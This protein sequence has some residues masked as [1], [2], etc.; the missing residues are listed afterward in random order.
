MRIKFQPYTT[1]Q[2]EK[3]VQ[4]RLECEKKDGRSWSRRRQLGY[5][6][7][8]STGSC[9]TRSSCRRMVEL[10]HATQKTARGGGGHPADAEQP[11]GC[12]LPG[13]QLP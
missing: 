1:T 3:I 10:V 9:E 12:V 11:N 6:H 13:L 5:D 8:L 4:G 2:L 7:V